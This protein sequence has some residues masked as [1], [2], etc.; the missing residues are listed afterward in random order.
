MF[1]INV[2]QVPIVANPLPMS[3][4]RSGQAFD[5]EIPTDTIT[6]P[7]AS[8]ITYEVFDQPLWMDFH[9]PNKSLTGNPT[10]DNVGTYV[11][12]VQGAD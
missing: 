5:L 1:E 8:A 4:Q 6:D 10:E 7:E 9:K 3:T 11:L 2:N 12:T